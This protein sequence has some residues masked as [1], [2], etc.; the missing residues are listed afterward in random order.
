MSPR[1]VQ[2]G[3]VVGATEFTQ[4]AN[5][6]ELAASYS[7]QLQ[8]TIHQQEMIVNQLNAYRTQLQ[9]TKKLDGLNWENA[10]GVLNQLANNAKRTN[11]LAYVFATEDETFKALHKDYGEFV[12]QEY[13]TADL[14]EVYRQW[15]KF[16]S[17][18]ATRAAKAA[19]IALDD[20][21]SEEARIKA[22]KAAGGSSEGQMQA[23]MAGNALSAEL[24]DQMRVLKELTAQQ[25]DAQ[26]RY[27]LI[28]QERA[29][30]D[31][32][33]DA[34]VMDDSDDESPDSKGYGKMK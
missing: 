32:A 7:E 13:K 25:I 10:T 30:H 26:A 1:R 3:A 6:M 20:A 19:G 23:I 18:A 5:N 24:L 21:R 12:K 15:S 9:N 14:A 29:S 2:A 27:Q 22:L 11:G 4:I 33:F 17:E 28:E 8:H 31:T 34:A 16:N